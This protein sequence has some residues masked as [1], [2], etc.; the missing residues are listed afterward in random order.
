MTW[1]PETLGYYIQFNYSLNVGI[2]DD[3]DKAVRE[4]FRDL[5]FRQA[6]SYATDRDGIAQSIMK[7]P[8]LR[9]WAGG[10]YPGAPDFD[11]NRSCTIPMMSTS[12]RSCWTRSA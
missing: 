7:G 8:F 9:G 5:R 6:L 12:P 2:K 10:L 4:L 1:G 3:R 11:K